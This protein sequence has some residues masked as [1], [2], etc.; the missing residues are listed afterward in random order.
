MKNVR[1]QMAGSPVNI[2]DVEITPLIQV[3]EVSIGTRHGGLTLSSVRPKAVEVRDG[4][5]PPRLMKIPDPRRWLGPAGLVAAAL[6]IMLR[7]RDD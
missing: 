5:G 3:R 7:R 1:R 6:L 4:T 2:D